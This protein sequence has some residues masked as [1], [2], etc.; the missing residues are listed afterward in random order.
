MNAYGYGAAL[1]ATL[2]KDGLVNAMLVKKGWFWTSLVG[3]WCIIRY[4]AVPGA[5]GETED[6]LSSHSKGMPY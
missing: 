3:W 1:Q 2:N 5:T 6:T 4:R